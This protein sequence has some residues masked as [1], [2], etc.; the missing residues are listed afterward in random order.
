MFHNTT[1]SCASEKVLYYLE[2][3]AGKIPVGNT[4]GANIPP[5]KPLPIL[6]ELLSTFKESRNRTLEEMI[7]TMLSIGK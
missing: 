1:V 7:D 2:T 3:F 6:E 5:L 4:G